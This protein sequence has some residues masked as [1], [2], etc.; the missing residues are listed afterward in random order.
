MPEI[1]LESLFERLGILTTLREQT[2]QMPTVQ[3]KLFDGQIVTAIVV[4]ENPKTL[5]VQ[6]PDGNVIKRHKAKHLVSLRGAKP[7]E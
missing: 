5:W 7:Q 2:K 6:L 3:V 4:K 1:I